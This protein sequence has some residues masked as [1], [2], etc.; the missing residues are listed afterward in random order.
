MGAKIMTKHE[1]DAI[2]RIRSDLGSEAAEIAK[3]VLRRQADSRVR[4]LAR[5]VGLRVRCKQGRYTILRTFSDTVEIESA[6][7][8]TVVAWIME[9]A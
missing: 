7:E 3:R 5:M 8:A 9:F 6:T 4:A 1:H 2:E